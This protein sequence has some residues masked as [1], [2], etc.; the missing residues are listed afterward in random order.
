MSLPHLPAP[1][2]PRSIVGPKPLEA[3]S[4]ALNSITN[5]MVPVWNPYMP[6]GAAPLKGEQHPARAPSPVAR[7]HFTLNIH[8]PHATCHM[9]HATRATPPQRPFLSP[10]TPLLHGLACHTPHASLHALHHLPNA[11]TPCTSYP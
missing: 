3:V 5:H 10:P 11:Y 1:A 8:V 6:K 7:P 2:P 4:R 9:P